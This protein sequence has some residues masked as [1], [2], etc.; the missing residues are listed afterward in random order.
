M[1]KKLRYNSIMINK[2]NDRCKLAM[3][4]FYTFWT[5]YMKFMMNPDRNLLE[6]N[7]LIPE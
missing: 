7:L 5:Y 4:G 6:A 1:S 2:N 3:I